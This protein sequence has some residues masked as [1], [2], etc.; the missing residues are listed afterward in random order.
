[1]RNR[2]ANSPLRRISIYFIL[3]AIV[4]FLLQLV[5]FSR[6]RVLFP[7]GMVVAGVSVGGLDRPESAQ[8]LQEVYSLPVELYYE[9]AAIHL[10][11][12]VVG[13]QLDLEK[14][15]ASADK[16]RVQQPFWAGFRNFLWRQPALSTEIPLQA[17]YSEARLRA[18]LIDELAARYDKAPTATLPVAGTINFQPG[19]Q[20]TKLDI[21]RSISLI[22][23][24]L[25]SSSKRVVILPL[26]RTRPP[27]PTLQNLEILL[28]Q[29]IDLSAFDGLA[30]LF[31]LDLQTG[32]EI[33][34]L[35]RQGEE[36]KISPDVSFTAASIIKIP[37]MVSVFKRIGENPDP[38]T[39]NLLE[40]MI[41]RSGNDPADWVMERVIDRKIAPMQ[42][43]ADMTALGLE[44]TFLAGQ[45]YPGAPLLAIFQ[46]PANQR[47]DVNTDPDI[48]NQ[49]TP[50]DIG[51]LLEDIYQC[52]QFGGGTLVAVFP[53]EITQ[54][55]CRT[56]IVFLTRNKLGS[57]IEAGV[58][59]GTR[60]AH[61]H[62]WVTLFGIMNTLGD[63]AIV[64]TPVGDYVLVIFLHQPVQL[65]WDPA[66]QLV[67]DLSQA[68]Y[69][70]FNLPIQ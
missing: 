53:G 31:L 11:P 70:F 6:L 2:S 21:E 69:N 60:V 58:P 20:G 52:S 45:F 7:A 12:P 28:K 39:I 14:M 47:F 1:L 23:D 50:S 41:E 42:V 65:L 33:H 64:Y 29:T 43:S 38:E 54:I 17:S 22:E 8:R 48:Y 4:L 57:L 61:K 3:A 18:Y 66:S 51:M 49:T 9:D 56:M 34:F 44:N 35:Y 37:I 15:L 26:A 32:Q 10:N 30:G 25:R 55:E 62:G 36:L 13:F 24:A 5:Q 59:D 16:V 27:R 63:A 67:A 46:T 68:I 19:N 40:K